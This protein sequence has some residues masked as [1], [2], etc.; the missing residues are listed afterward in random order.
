MGPDRLL[1]NDVNMLPPGGQYNDEHGAA[2]ILDL[3][4]R[5]SE[6]GFHVFATRHTGNWDA[7]S[8]MDP[9]VS[10]MRASR[11]PILF[12]DNDGDTCK[13]VGR[14]KAQHLPPGRGILLSPDEQREGVLVGSCE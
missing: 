8:M 11:A 7:V 2:P 4:P 9:F 1:L 10:R 12:M 13:I 5:A 3:I 6:I 14:I